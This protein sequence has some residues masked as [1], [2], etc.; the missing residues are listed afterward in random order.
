M[1]GIRT[2]EMSGRE[3]AAFAALIAREAGIHLT[4]LKRD[5]LSAR[6]QRRVRELGLATFGE[7]L[8]LV[9]APRSAEERTRMI[10]AVCTNETSF[11]RERAQFD[12][13]ASVV[14]P[15]WEEQAR[16]GLRPRRISAWSAACAT[17]EEPFS[18]AMMLKD[19]LPGFTLD[20]LGT[21]LSTRALAAARSASFPLDRSHPIPRS[22][23][24]RYMLRGTGAHEGRMTAK[25]E[26]REVVRLA[27]VNLV[28]GL[29]SGSF[30][31]LFC[32]NVLIY[33]DL[34]TKQRVLD[35]LLPRL[36]PGGL[37]LLGQ[38]ESLISLRSGLESFGPSIHGRPG[39]WAEG[40]WPPR[41][42][43]RRP[44]TPRLDPGPRE[45]QD[46]SSAPA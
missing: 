2:P 40:G 46:G 15:I 19:R 3:L 30:D 29:P 34:P 9:T 31:L 43:L 10:D 45:S 37:L 36:A 14:L 18:I 23:L 22:Y 20:V 25:P 42:K 24:R 38:A 39:E 7:Y 44:E 26:L 17:G 32:R 35:R 27:P 16:R 12:L 8:D 6:L 21:D 5:M 4:D 28:S 13:L 33:F 1:D 11:F 41:S